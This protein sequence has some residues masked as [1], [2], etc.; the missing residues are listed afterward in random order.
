MAD[1][2]QD[3]TAPFRAVAVY[4]DPAQ[5]RHAVETL[6]RH[7]MGPEEVSFLPSGRAGGEQARRADLATA[8]Y[9]GAA[10][11]RWAVVGGLVGALIGFVLFQVF[12]FGSGSAAWVFVVGTAIAGALLGG[13]WGG[14]SKLPVNAEGWQDTFGGLAN[15]QTGLVL[16][17]DDADRFDTAVGRLRSTSPVVVRRLEHDEPII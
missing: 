17:T 7:G 2:T 9:L 8:G 11:V 6:E 14:A 5:A 3:H 16:H 10:V 12:G 13:Y 4:D 15:G 1:N